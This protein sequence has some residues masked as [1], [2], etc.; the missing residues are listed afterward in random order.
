M[1]GWDITGEDCRELMEAIKAD[2]E[3]GTMTQNWS[4]RR[5]NS[6][7]EYFLWINIEVRT[8]VSELAGKGLEIYTDAENTMKWLEAHQEL[9]NP[10]GYYTF[11]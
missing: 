5:R 11:D 1:D 8:G 3:A 2:C 10:E 4:Y 7:S 6:K 9:W